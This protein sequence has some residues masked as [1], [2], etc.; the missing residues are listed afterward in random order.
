MTRTSSSARTVT[1][2]FRWEVEVLAA[3]T[4]IFPSILI[5]PVSLLVNVYW[6]LLFTVKANRPPSD[7][8]EM[9]EGE[10]SRNTASPS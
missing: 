2:P 9:L 7:A 6:V 5:Q 1:L 10:T 8:A 3:T 4:M